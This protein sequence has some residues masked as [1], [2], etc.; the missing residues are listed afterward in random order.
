MWTGAMGLMLQLQPPLPRGFT[1]MWAC[2][3]GCSS[4]E[5]FS[6][7]HHLQKPTISKIQVEQEDVKSG[8]YVHNP[9]YYYVHIL[10]MTDD[11]GLYV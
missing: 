2:V 10:H 8:I 4:T 6:F 3:F 5:A 9:H 1:G 11:Y 7:Q